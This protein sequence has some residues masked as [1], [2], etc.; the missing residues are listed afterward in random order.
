MLSLMIERFCLVKSFNQ[1]GQ[2]AD[3][4]YSAPTNSVAV[5]KHHA[6]SV[7]G[8]YVVKVQQNRLLSLSVSYLNV[9]FLSRKLL[10]H[11]N[12][13]SVSF[14]P[15]FLASYVAILLER[16]SRR[17]LLALYVTNVVSYHVIIIHC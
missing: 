10:G 13:L 15:A 12:V 5:L 7:A 11:F 14:L 6:N 4:F 16:P 2:A 9:T 8:Q 17:S 3:V 1:E